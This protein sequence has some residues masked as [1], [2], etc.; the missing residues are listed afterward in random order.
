MLDEHLY[1]LT[2]QRTDTTYARNERLK[3]IV[4]LAAHGSES[5]IVRLKR[6]SPEN[7]APAWHFSSAD[8]KSRVKSVLNSS[9]VALGGDDNG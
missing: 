3:H 2:G 6:M 7:R 8:I 4:W 1:R 9:S 5:A